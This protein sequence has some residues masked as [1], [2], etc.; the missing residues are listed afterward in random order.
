MM[1]V[2]IFVAR[3]CYNLS[4]W[5]DPILSFWLLIILIM[6]FLILLVFPWRSFFF[7]TSL[8]AMGPQVS[9]RTKTIF[10]LAGY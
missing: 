6:L 1:R 7:L 5:R 8:A 9:F 3:L 4:C 10:L 2:F